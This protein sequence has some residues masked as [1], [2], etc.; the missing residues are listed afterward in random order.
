MAYIRLPL[1]VKVSLEYTLGGKV[2]VNIYH[3]TTTDPIVTVKLEDIAQV[4]IDWAISKLLTRLS[5]NIVL[6]AATAQNLDVENGEKITI[7]VV[8][9]EPGTVLQQAVSNNVA[10]VVSMRTDLTGRSFQGRSYIAGLGDEDVAGNY[11]DVARATQFITDFVQLDANLAVEDTSLVIA[12]F[13]HAGVPREE[14]VATR[15][16]SYLVNTRV[17]TQRRRLPKS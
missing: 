5:Q 3:V 17:D 14:G 6:F 16:T 10:L 13:Q 12:S 9:P 11:I 1:G 7:A 2:V 15:V 4:F 8:P